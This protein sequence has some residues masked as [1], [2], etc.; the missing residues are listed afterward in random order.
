MQ[1]AKSNRGYLKRPIVLSNLQW[2]C[3]VQGDLIKVKGHLTDYEP[4][5]GGR[6]G[7]IGTFSKAA[8]K[9][10]LEAVATIE[11]DT[12]R[13]GLFLTLTYP[14]S[15]LPR[16][17]DQRRDD[18]YVFFRSMENYLGRQFG[19]LWRI[20]WKRRK[21]GARRGEVHPHL[22]A[23]IFGVRFFPYADLR[24]CWRARLGCKGALS[25]RVDSLATKSKHGVYIAKYAAKMPEESY[26]DNVA[27]CNIDGKH[28]GTHRRELIPRE[29]PRVFNDLPPDVVERLRA[30]A[31]DTL[32]WYDTRY[33]AGFSIFGK[34]GERLKGAVEKLCL[35]AG[36]T[37]E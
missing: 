7:T 25:T 33:D 6:R 34:L 32:P 8:R 23:I 10:M 9:R 1:D 30:T 29:V 5:R 26:L 16:S 18:R 13:Y 4:Q 19:A 21:R 14:D 2:Q 35:D 31:A 27:Y 36:L 3:T 22:H 28:W 20:E 24:K 17:A 15:V 12:I 11:W 37:P